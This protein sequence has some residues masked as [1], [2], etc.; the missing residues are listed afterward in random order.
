[1]AEGVNAEK[2]GKDDVII[3]TNFKLNLPSE[4]FKQSHSKVCRGINNGSGTTRNE[5]ILYYHPRRE[6][7]HQEEVGSRS[8]TGAK[9]KLLRGK[10][11]KTNG[12][13]S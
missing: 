9:G 12:K 3:V 8:G 10:V 11:T 5:G 4:L 6:W 2:E 1:M 7:E 13:K